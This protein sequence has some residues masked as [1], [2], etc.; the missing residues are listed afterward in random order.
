MSLI[1]HFK[2]FAQYHLLKNPT[3]H[4]TAHMYLYLLFCLSSFLLF[5]PPN[6]FTF[7]MWVFSHSISTTMRPR[8]WRP[9]WFLFLFV[10]ELN[11]GSAVVRQELQT[12]MRVKYPDNYSLYLLLN[13]CSSIH[14]SWQLVIWKLLSFTFSH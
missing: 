5:V 2:Y 3:N 12:V 1:I 8:R 7:L 14:L 9:L 10:S 11:N 13:I 6:T 4:C